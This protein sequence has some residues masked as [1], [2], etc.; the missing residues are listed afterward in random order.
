MISVIVVTYNQ[1]ASIGRCLDAIMC[2]QTTEPFE[3][4]VGDDCS[5]D[6]TPRICQEYADRYPDRIRLFLRTH[7]IGLLDNY[8]SLVREARGEFLIDCAGDD[9]WLPTR[10]SVCLD[11]MRQYP[12]VVHVV[13]DAWNRCDS[14]GIVSESNAARYPEGIIKGM[15]LSHHVLTTQRNQIFLGMMR[16]SAVQE[17]M[18]AYPQFFTG[19]TYPLEDK[20]IITLLGLKGD[21]YY[22]PEKTFYYTIDNPSSVMHTTNAMSRFRFYGSLINLTYRLAQ[23]MHVSVWQMLPMYCFL[24]SL[25]WRQPLRWM[26]AKILSH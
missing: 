3:V 9:E 2:Q 10:I 19:R 25:R 20:Q 1:Q 24:L 7:N 14:T 23:V 21:T 4:L 15:E 12:N 17:V 8:Y 5:Q 18:T 13:T 16:T 6:D 22:S 26:A 11:V